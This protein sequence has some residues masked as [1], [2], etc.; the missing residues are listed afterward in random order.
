MNE[1]TN[2]RTNEQMN[3][4][5]TN[6]FTCFVYFVIIKTQNR[7]PNNMQ[8]TSLQSYKTQ[9]KILPYPGLISFIRQLG[10]LT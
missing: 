8:K 5:Y 6:V 1:R 2:E 7:N 10:F 3:A 4:F 9:I